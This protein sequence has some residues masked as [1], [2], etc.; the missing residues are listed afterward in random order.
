MLCAVHGQGWAGTKESKVARQR[1]PEILVLSI[2][3]PMVVSSKVCLLVHLNS[4]RII[5]SLF[6]AHGKNAWNYME[7]G[8]G[9]FYLLIHTMSTFWA[10]Q[11]LLLRIRNFR[12]CWIPRFWISRSPD[13]QIPRF[14]GSQISRRRRRRRRRRTNSQIPT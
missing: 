6:P 10:E 1:D 5:F 7:E 9:H 11:I 14:R 2:S 4:K 8:P 13:Y 12:I 3:P